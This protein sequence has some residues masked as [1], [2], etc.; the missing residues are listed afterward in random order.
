M[1]L[2]LN[3]EFQGYIPVEVLDMGTPYREVYLAKNNYEQ[4]VVLTVYDMNNLPECLAEGKIPEFA[5]IP[6]LSNYTFPKYVEQGTY[7]AD[8]VSLG[9]MTSKYIGHTTLTDFIM[10]G[11]AV[12]EQTSLLQFYNL[13][14]AL[15]EL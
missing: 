10:S 6:R 2:K 3:K 14:L 11:N 12:T 8:G 5:V 7:N 1:I 4:E 15:K 13:L 9:W